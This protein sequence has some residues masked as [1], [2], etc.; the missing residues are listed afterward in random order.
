MAS[1]TQNWAGWHA[2]PPLPP[3]AFSVDGGS[4]P[5][6]SPTQ[7]IL[8][9]ANEDDMTNA[10]CSEDESYD[11]CGGQGEDQPEETTPNVGRPKEFEAL[12]T[13]TQVQ[14]NSAMVESPKFPGQAGP[15]DIQSPTSPG[16]S[17]ASGMSQQVSELAMPNMSAPRPRPPPFVPPHHS[18]PSQ[19]ASNAP[20]MRPRPQPPSPGAGKCLPEEVSPLDVKWGVLFDQNG[21][22]TRRWDQVLRGIGN[23]L[24]MPQK[25][26]VITPGKMAAF[27]SQHPL[28]LEPFQYT[29]IFRTSQ[30]PS[31]TRLAEVYEQLACEYYLVPAEPKARPTVPGL[32]L[33]GWT[34]WMTLAMRAYPN[35]EA[36]R[37]ANV[38]AA[39][40]INADSLLDGKPERLP[41][42]ISRR[43]LPEKA[44]RQARMLFNRALK[45]HLEAT[46]LPSNKPPLEDAERRASAC[47][48]PASPRS[49]YRPANLPFPSPSQASDDIDHHSRRR[50]D[51]DLDRERDRERSYRGS[52]GHVRT[53]GESIQ[54]TARRDPPPSPRSPNSS[55]TRPPP[56]PSPPPPSSSSF[57]SS[58]R[59]RTS[60][61]PSTTHPPPQPF[62]SSSSATINHRHSVAGVIG[63]NGR[64]GS[65]TVGS[66]GLDRERGC[67][68]PG[69]LP[70]STSDSAVS[71]RNRDRDRDRARE[72]ER[73]RGRERRRDS[74][75][76]E[77]ERDR[78]RERE[79]ERETDNSR[80]ER[81]RGRKLAS[82]ADHY[83]DRKSRGGSMRRTLVV[84][85]DAR[86]ERSQTWG[87]FLAGR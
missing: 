61:F 50:T 45:P 35:E 32:T 53:Y 28:E 68:W 67:T 21:L 33:S 46:A 6:P 29:D 10:S 48:R 2:P 73:D 43:L 65:T 64:N 20:E 52:A 11:E 84:V 56:P 54:P 17:D 31:H 60:P 44:D 3:A 82:V 74:R 22:P 25:T 19:R 86:D 38:V 49:R 85:R 58:S 72:K 5:F 12:P 75:E 16:T 30:G 34:R 7:S 79:R 39:L 83:S 62:S 26:L 37:L 4:F 87:E 81:P 71:S 63:S 24:L 51:R 36:Q 41:K 13:I 23:Y 77:K 40:P 8:Q 1:Q 9:D 66:G 69:Y 59:R 15:L 80:R 55:S 76:R 47:S 78:E 14:A 18:F 27:Y 70:R 42:Q 57:T